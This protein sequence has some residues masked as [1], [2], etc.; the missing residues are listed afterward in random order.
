[1]DALTDKVIGAAIGVHRALG[2]G[3]LE[4]VYEVCLAYD[5]REAG[6]QV[7]TQKAVSLRYRGLVFDASYRLDMVIDNRLVLELKA[8][9]N[10]SPLHRAQLL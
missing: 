6:V 1:L 5:L 8:V 3:L 10:L 4:S 9:E 7:D 2:P